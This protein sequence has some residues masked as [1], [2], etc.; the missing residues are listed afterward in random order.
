[1][2]IVLENTS[3]IP[4]RF[5][6]IVWGAFV[7]SVKEGDKTVTTEAWVVGDPS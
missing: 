1:M 7:T 6:A 2:S 3:T 4:A 5:E